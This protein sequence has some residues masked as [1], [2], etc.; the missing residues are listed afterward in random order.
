[1]AEFKKRQTAYKLCISQI[2]SGEQSFDESTGY[3][4]IL[5]RDMASQVI[6]VSKI[7]IIANVVDKY[8]SSGEKKY[9][10]LTLDDATEQIRVKTFGE[11][12]SKVGAIAIGDTVSVIGSLRIFNDEVYIIPEIVRLADPKWLY[13]RKLEIASQFGNIEKADH[14]NIQTSEGENNSAEEIEQ[15]DIQEGKVSNPV[16][17]ESADLKN[18]I[19]S[20]IKENNEEISIEKLILALNEPIEQINS[21]INELLDSNVVYEPKPGTLRLL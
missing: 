1:M 5:L 7:N 16:K 20:R 17:I 21:S 13:V 15:M 9:S 4:S 6:N 12:I 11:E 18:K 2:M 19:I 8:V 14:S 3:F 10:S